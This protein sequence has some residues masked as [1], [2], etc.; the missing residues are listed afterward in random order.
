MLNMLRKSA[1]RRELGQ[2]LE[3]A[4]SAQARA[5]AFFAALG[6]PDTMDGRFDMVALH[7]Y[8]ALTHLKAS[9]Q[10][11]AAQALTDALFLGF[12]EALREQGISDMGMGRRMKSIANAFYG[13]LSAYGAAGNDQEMAQALARNVWRG[14]AV[15]ENARALAAY[16]AR[17]R[18]V[19]A[20]SPPGTLDFGPLPSC[21]GP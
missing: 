21:V 8:L 4:L 1:A 7:A 5:P 14:G 20:A 13:R 9:G 12:D 16:V 18:A 6:V 3:H 15:D 19:I 10:D 2:A 17:T 11:Q